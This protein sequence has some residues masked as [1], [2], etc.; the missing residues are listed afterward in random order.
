MS[1]T[2]VGTIR[3]AAFLWMKRFSCY[4]CSPF[5][6]CSEKYCEFWG[7]ALP[8]LCCGGCAMRFW[9]GAFR[10]PPID[11]ASLAAAL[12]DAWTE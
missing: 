3:K 12:T 5:F 10:R 7:G 2:T 1:Q 4:I 9:G 8:L 11:F 6:P